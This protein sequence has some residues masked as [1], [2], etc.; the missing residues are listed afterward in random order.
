[1]FLKALELH[2]FKSFPDKTVLTFE[3]GITAVVGP[4]GSGKSNISDA[5]RWVLGEQSNKNLRGSK[6]QDVIFSGTEKR[7]G[8]G[9]AEVSL[10]ID[11][12]DKTLDFDADDVKVTRRYYRSGDSEYLLNNATVR[13]KDVQMLFMDTGLG[14]DGY[15]MIGQGRIDE[16]VSS[17]SEERRAIFEEAA[18]IAKYRYRKS[19]AERR[20]QAAEESLVR[21][22]DIVHELEERVGP[23]EHQAEKAKRFLTLAAEKKEIEISLWIRSLNNS[24][25]VLRDLNAKW[26]LARRQYEE[27]GGASDQMDAEVEKLAADMQQ[28]QVELEEKRRLAYALDEQASSRD[29]DVNILKNDIFHNGENIARI[30]GEQE[31][32]AVG[33]RQIE[34][35]IEA[36][37]ALIA[38]KRQEV[39]TANQ[40]QIALAEELDSL[41]KNSDA[42]SAEM[43]A[44]SVKAN[45]IA[46]RLSDIR[47]QKVTAESSLAEM[48]LQLS[49]MNA[50]V[51]LRTAQK[52]AADE[53]RA[54]CEADGKRCDETIA[55]RQNVLAGYQRKCAAVS[56]KAEAARQSAETLRQETLEKERRVKLLEELERNME[57]LSGSVKLIVKQAER[58]AL[59]GIRGPISSLINADR[60]YALAIE[61]A[62]GGAL[63]HIV[64]EREENAKQGIAFLK[65]N[66]AGRATFL[67]MST[68]KGSR[69]SEK[70]LEQ[71]DGYV[72][73]AS[74][75]A[76]CDA[77]YAPIAENL[78]G[79]TVV[80]ED[81]DYAVAIAKR[82]GHRFRVVTLDGQIVNAGGSMTG[83]SHVKNAGLLSRRA[84]IERWQQ[85][86]ED[87]RA[88]AAKADETAKKIEQDLAA[89]QAALS[90]A[91]AELTTA[92]EDKIRLEG[93]LRRLTDAANA[94]GAALAAL[95][96]DIARVGERVT[97]TTAVKENADAALSET[98]AE[99]VALEAQLAALTGGRQELTAKREALSERL[100]DAKLRVLAIEKEIEAAEGAIEEL[101][102]R[103][104][105]S[106]AYREELHRQIAAIE[107][108]NAGIEQKIAA[109][110][111]DAATLREQANAVRAMME[112][113]VASRNE[114]EARQ[115]ALRQ[116][117]REKMEERE[118]VS[119]DLV[120]LEEKTHNAEA[121]TEN[122][123]RRLY[124]EYELT[125]AAA[126][127]IAKPI[128]NAAEA[129][130]RLSE[131]KNKIRALGNV[132]VGAI[133]EYQEV[134]ERYDFLS[135]QVKDVEVSKE[136][137]QKLI[138]ELTT[139][140][141]E[142]FTERFEKI[143][144][145][146]AETFS[147][148]FV[149]GKA[150]LSLSD[151][152]DVLQSGIEIN[153]QPPGKKIL[154]LASLSGG[155]KALVAISLLFA[156]LKVTPSPFCVFDEIEAALDDVNVNR[157]AQYL[158]RMDKTQF[159]VITHRRGT[160][161]EADVL[162]GITMQEKGVSKM[163][164][165]H[166]GEV[167]EKLG[168]SGDKQ[169][170]KKGNTNGTVQ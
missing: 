53:E 127:E 87:S 94:A 92:T 161:E 149:G 76:V 100:S 134:S 146:F 10:I 123:T 145:H 90:G 108:Q 136:E 115:T 71:E 107:A 151:P 170:G 129:G 112:T 119:R 12:H 156:I 139:Q 58:G 9:F 13:L 138:R 61:T 117:A 54:A 164:E 44:L 18:G 103:C 81:L 6:L 148:L 34:E 67:P 60:Q 97:E 126:E 143:N 72:G 157:F 75:L 74:D 50:A 147:E 11:N 48:A 89:L 4:N 116:Q 140:M 152:L 111:A 110:T 154:S 158:R 137:L 121:E 66:N 20:L 150:E 59:R 62:L 24:R 21:L 25:D 14:R 131:L 47:V 19:D 32:S 77:A 1:M 28:A 142:I 46:T 168:I 160:M 65:E 106:S 64:C 120:R 166:A 73:I 23:L 36:K 109:A 52:A 40:A 141:Q 43:E 95:T 37:Q 144:R 17:K 91:T 57:G 122:I 86:A 49:G 26:E 163:L 162:Y 41:A 15:S 104:T 84:E 45:A 133:E 22:R 3:K 70:G 51:A 88:K 83:G 132:N 8:V 29:A 5:I 165:L 96:A 35:E 30:R 79:K 98:E 38:G 130:R 125:R 33:D 114:M 167:E 63:Q 31:Q 169:E 124:E 56:E 42:Y 113:V 78:L 101:R 93:E 159:I 135:G 128:E 105:S 99:R 2:G 68:V 27:A 85:A 118:K 82:Y 16:I 39:E 69:L 7:K 55:E 102:R 80:A 153:V 155:E